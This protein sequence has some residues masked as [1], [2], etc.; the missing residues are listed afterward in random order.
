MLL[1]STAQI[2]HNCTLR[3]DLMELFVV[4]SKISFEL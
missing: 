2:V 3:V 1:K 4:V